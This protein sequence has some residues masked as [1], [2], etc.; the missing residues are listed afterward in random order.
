MAE[1]EERRSFLRAINMG[2]YWWELA[3]GICHQNSRIYLGPRP[4]S[5]VQLS[6]FRLHVRQG[7]VQRLRGRSAE[8]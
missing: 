6:R 7:S 5:E 3:L 1:E 2:A 8:P 4:Y